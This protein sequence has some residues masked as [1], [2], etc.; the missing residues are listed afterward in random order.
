M[1]LVGATLAF[2][3]RMRKKNLI[4]LKGWQKKNFEVFW[5]IRLS[6]LTFE[7]S[8]S[9]ESVRKILIFSLNVLMT[10]LYLKYFSIL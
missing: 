7:L 9:I 6:L 10:V 2:L 4:I 5:F 8:I 1:R 3:R